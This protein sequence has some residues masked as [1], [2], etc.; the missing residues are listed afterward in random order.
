[1]GK[2]GDTHALS[3]P[4]DESGERMRSEQEVIAIAIASV[5]YPETEWTNFTPRRQALFME[6]AARAVAA[7]MPPLPE[8]EGEPGDDQPEYPA[9]LLDAMAI[10][11]A[12]LA[13]NRIPTGPGGERPRQ[14]LDRYTQE[15]GRENAP[16]E[17]AVA[18][19]ELG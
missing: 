14:A 13:T 9:E 17:I 12:L 2:N 19:G 15:V 5:E 6:M 7:A 11:I 4:L 3:G 16:E 1:M 10:T 18:I 8:H